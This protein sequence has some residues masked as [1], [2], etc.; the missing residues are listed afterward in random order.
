M[1]M[2]RNLRRPFMPIAA[3]LLLFALAAAAAEPPPP[4]EPAAGQLLVAAATMQDPRFAHSVI[5][6]LRHDKTGAFGLIINRP[7]AERPLADVIAAIGG[8]SGSAASGQSEKKPAATLGMIRVFFGGPVQPQLGFVVH[9]ADYH[10]PGTLAVGN[11]LAM[12]ADK[13][14]LLDIA[15][16][17]GPA[18]YLFALGYA[19]WGPGQLEGEFARRDWF[20]APAEPDIVFDAP[21]A[22]VWKKALA[23][24]TREL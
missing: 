4:P 13:E 8:K 5:L 20:T 12:T 15:H 14:V 22:A 7:I 24:R 16:H 18:R 23:S 17:K 9:G 6:L 1:T 2:A 10:R 21:R 19:G 3:A 11:G